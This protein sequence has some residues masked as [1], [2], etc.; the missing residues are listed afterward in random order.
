MPKGIYKH[1]KHSEDWKQKLKLWH[2]DNKNTQKYKEFREKC[3]EKAFLQFKNGM[4][5]ETKTKISVAR[6]GIKFSDEHKQNLKEAF[7]RLRKPYENFSRPIEKFPNH[8]MRGKLHSEETKEKMRTRIVSDELKEKIRANHR[9]GPLVGHTYSDKTKQKMRVAAIEYIK[10]TRGSISPNVGR[11]EKQILDALQDRLG[12][13]IKRQFYI[14]GYFL[15]GYC[16]E[17]NLA[18]EIDEEG[19][20]KNNIL[21]NRDL[22]KQNNIIN[23]LNCNFLRIRVKEVIIDEQLNLEKLNSESGRYEIKCQ[24]NH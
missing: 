12:F 22:N 17:I 14:N 4:P 7:L 5:E 10:N 1:K 24:S 13:S 9:G 8:G 2:T 15:D 20:Y 11:Y 21:N 16:Q 23:S 6:I 18:I 3:S 19:H